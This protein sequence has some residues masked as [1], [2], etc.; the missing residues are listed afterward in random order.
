M[1]VADLVEFMQTLPQQAEVVMEDRDFAK[2]GEYVALR[3]V[4]AKAQAR[5]REK[6]Q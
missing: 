4:Y 1:T 5:Q 3:T 2:S 6:V